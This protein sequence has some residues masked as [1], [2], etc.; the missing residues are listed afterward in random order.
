MNQAEKV[1]ALEQGFWQYVENMNELKEGKKVEA[2]EQNIYQQL[3][4]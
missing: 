2:L 1:E 3:E 4:K